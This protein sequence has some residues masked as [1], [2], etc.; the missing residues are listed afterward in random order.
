[1]GGMGQLGTLSLAG[2]RRRGSG[3]ATGGGAVRGA[4][5]PTTERSQKGRKG[6]PTCVPVPVSAAFPGV[7]LQGPLCDTSCVSM[8]VS[9]SVCPRVCPSP[10]GSI[11]SEVSK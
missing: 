10:F 11:G 3:K 2:D 4:G 9:L 1:M 8:P 6:S 5:E 7:C